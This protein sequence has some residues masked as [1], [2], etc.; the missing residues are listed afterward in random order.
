M[1]YTEDPIVSTDIVGS[2][3]SSIVDSK[4]TAVMD[5]TMLKVV[6]WYDNEW[7]YSNRLVDLVPEGP[8]GGRRRA[9]GAST[10]STSHGRRVLVRVDFN[11]PLTVGAD[12]AIQIADDTRIRAALPTLAGAARARRAAGPRLAPRTVPKGRRVPGLSLRAGRRAPARAAGRRAGDARPGR[13]RRAG[14]ARSPSSCATASC[15]CSRTSASSPARRATTPSSRAPSRSSPTSTSTTPSAPP[16]AHTRARPASRTCCRTPPDG[17]S[18]ARCARSR[19]SGE[20]RATIGRRHRRR[21]GGR[22]DRGHRPLPGDRRRDPDRR[23]DVLPLPRRPG[24]RRSASRC[25]TPRTSSTPAT[26]SLRRRQ[27]QHPSAR[28]RAR[29]ELPSDLV[30]ADR[31]AAEAEHRVLDGLDVPDGWMG[32]DIGPATA[33]RYAAEIARPAPSSGTARWVPSSSSPFAA[34][35][36]AVAEAV[37]RGRRRSA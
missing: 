18:N 5:G 8:L 32:L 24:P 17:C 1:A 23:R 3:Y 28:S 31:F 9:C 30:I 13:R 19:V 4:L 29:L 20:P 21:E 11:V 2:S 7:G 6:A 10:I 37:A 33:A 27:A 15:C 16:T 36:R 35:T 12:G 26:P 14:A 25:A 34:G 22:Q